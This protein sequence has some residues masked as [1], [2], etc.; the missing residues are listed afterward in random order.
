MSKSS[1][2]TP[3]APRRSGCPIA[4]TLD[5]VGDKWTLVITRDLINGKRR[6]GDLLDSPEGIPTNIL[7]DR[8]KRMA[9]AGLVEKR[10]YQQRPV[11]YE[12]HLTEKGEALLP[13]LQE[14]CR[15]ANAYYPDTWVPP[16]QFMQPQRTH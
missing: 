3:A 13:V 1:K 11:R 16:E 14:M 7:A 6:F 10:A 15:W 8:L 4:T 2:T 9:A 12:Y 5:L